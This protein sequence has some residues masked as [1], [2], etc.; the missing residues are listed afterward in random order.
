MTETGEL[1]GDADKLFGQRLKAPV[2]GD[3][4]FN[5]GS[6]VG[7]DALGKLPAVDIALQ[8]KVRTLAALGGGMGLLE[9]LTAQ[10]ATAKPVDSL[11]L[12]EDLVPAG[13][14]LRKGG[15]AIPGDSR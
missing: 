11:H 12:V 2:V 3:Q 7:R 15:S 5:L 14:E 6:L 1:V 4:G 8:N 9:V 13:F 10:R